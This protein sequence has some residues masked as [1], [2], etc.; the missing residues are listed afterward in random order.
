MKKKLYIWIQ[1]IIAATLLGVV[2][3]NFVEGLPKKE[4]KAKYIF[5]FIGDGMGFTHIAA[6]ESYLSYKEGKIGG[7]RLLFSTF[8]YCGNVSTYSANRN[9]TCS[10]ASGTAIACGEK[11]NNDMIGMNADSVA[12]YSMAAALKED[13]YKIGIITTAPVNHATPS[14]FYAH[15][16]NR[17]NAYEICCEI[18]ASGFEFFAGAGFLKHRGENEDQRPVGEILEENGYTVSYGIEEFKDKSTLTSKAILCQEGNL[19]KNAQ[20]YSVDY[21]EMGM[22]LRD[23]LKAGMAFI[24]EEE[25]FFFM[26]EG[27]MIDWGAHANSPMAVIHDIVDFDDAIREAYEFYLEHPDETLIIVTSDHE[28]GGMTLGTNSKK[29]KWAPLEEAWKVNHTIDLSQMM[30]NRELSDKCSIGWTSRSHTGAHV[31]IFAIG[32]GAEKF[33]GSMDNTDIKGKILCK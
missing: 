25:P 14:A 8:P 10:A 19:N 18:P 11:T 29:I 16:I 27:G 13:G 33:S 3:G 9:V 24:G 23:M 30:A 5:L 6:T 12:I 17:D 15:N 20:N 31:P 22:G 2:V 1:I 26:C 32:A 21:E 4:K 28:T 7:E